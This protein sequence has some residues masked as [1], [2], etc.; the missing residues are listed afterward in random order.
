MSRGERAAMWR[1]RR[2]TPMWARIQGYPEGLEH[3]HT[4]LKTLVLTAVQLLLIGC[5]LGADES[6]VL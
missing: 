4:H 5:L 2:A 3:Q 1:R 6:G